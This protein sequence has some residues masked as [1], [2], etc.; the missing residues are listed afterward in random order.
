MEEAEKAVNVSFLAL[1]GSA[2]DRLLTLN[3]SLVS[4]ILEMRDVYGLTLEF[5]ATA[6]SSQQKDRFKQTCRDT[7]TRFRGVIESIISDGIRRNEFK[8]T[9]SPHAIAAALMVTWDALGLQAWFENDL[10]IT[11]ISR[12]ILQ[13]LIEGMQL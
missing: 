10:D 11:S 9:L 8:P 1:G 3:D 6:S 2:T 7:Y 5:W 13:T 12:D 4:A